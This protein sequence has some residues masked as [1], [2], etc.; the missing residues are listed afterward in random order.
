[1]EHLGK[2]AVLLAGMHRSGT[3]AL[4]RSLNIW[5]CDISTDLMEGNQ[6]NPQGYW[7]SHGF[8]D[9]NEQI[10]RSL[11]SGWYG[12]TPLP[13][14][15]FH[16]AEAGRYRQEIIARLEQSFAASSL[17]VIKDPRL[18]LLLPL[19]RQAMEEFGAQPRIVIAVRNPSEVVRSLGRRDGFIEEY[20]LL[21]WIRYM[22]EAERHS[23]RCPRIFVPYTAH[24]Q[25]WRATRQRIAEALSLPIP[26]LSEE[27]IA[28][29]ETHLFPRQPEPT[30]MNL[31]GGALRE[32]GDMATQLSQRL[33]R[34]EDCGSI[35][36]DVSAML[37]NFLKP[38]DADHAE[39]R[40]AALFRSYET[41]IDK[42]YRAQ[43]HIDHLDRSFRMVQYRSYRLG[44]D[45]RRLQRTH[46]LLERG[47]SDLLR[48]Y[49][50][51][52]ARVR[53]LISKPWLALKKGGRQILPALRRI[54]AILLR[55]NLRTG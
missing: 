21:L 10:L 26:V 32:I 39:R 16:S 20:S 53:R 23:R 14:A 33:E 12:V 41:F 8:S 47:Y 3:S 52:V 25:D 22:V 34:G 55:L 17:F 46:R 38:G 50:R 2:I 7:E 51:R 1:M 36:T 9:L 15:F 19:W 45:H 30:T 48:Q 35:F 43:F 28:Q 40:L 24:L 29:M 44:E 11:G 37:E 6:H 5:G 54:R 13:E 49:R 27:K 31:L 4:A 42:F 18:S